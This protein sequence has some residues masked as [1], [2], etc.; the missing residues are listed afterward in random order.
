MTH[1]CYHSSLIYHTPAEEARG[2]LCFRF[3]LSRFVFWTDWGLDPKVERASLSGEDRKTLASSPNQQITWP[4]G[5][6]TDYVGKKIYW[7]DAKHDTIVSSDYDGTNIKSVRVRLNIHPFSVAFYGSSLYWSDWNVSPRTIMRLNM[8]TH[9][10]ATF[11]NLSTDKVTGIA[12]FD[13]SLQPTGTFQQFL[14]LPVWPPNAI[15]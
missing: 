11:G 6:T 9:T 13:S 14:Q 3:L 10:S 5:I 15:Q 1:I 2:N 12:V 8:N 7:V 4:N